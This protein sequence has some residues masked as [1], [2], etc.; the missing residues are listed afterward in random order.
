MTQGVY[1]I[2]RHE[3]VP[4]LLRGSFPV[5]VWQRIR[6]YLQTDIMIN[7]LRA[8]RAGQNLRFNLI[9]IQTATRSNQIVVANGLRSSAP[10]SPRSFVPLRSAVSSASVQTM[11][12]CNRARAS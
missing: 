7:E 11:S 10:I 9:L 6:S 4:I 5:I 12:R 1:V 3:R 8:S 2:Q